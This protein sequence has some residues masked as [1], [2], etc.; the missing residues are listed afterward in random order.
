MKHVRSLYAAL[1][2]ALAPWAM[3]TW[4]AQDEQPKPRQTPAV[5]SA[6]AVKVM[7]GKPR[8]QITQMDA[9]IDAM[10]AMHE[11]ML[12]AKTPEERN[13]MLAEHNQIMQDGLAMMNGQGDMSAH[14]QMLDKRLEM[15]QSMMQ[16]MVDRLPPATAKP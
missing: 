15:M 2:L 16:M 7:P 4:A 10:N 13:A 5:V 14:H 12:G 3:A 8:L 6:G 11:K 9:Q 1:A